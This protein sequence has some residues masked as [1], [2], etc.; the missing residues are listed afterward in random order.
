MNVTEPKVRTAADVDAALA[1]VI[2]SV[3]RA[4][5]PHRYEQH[6][7]VAALEHLWAEQHY[8][9]D[10]LRRLHERVMVGGR[11]LALELDRYFELDD[12]GAKND[13][14]IEVGT[15]LGEQAIREA[16]DAVGLEPRD[17]DAIF[18]TTVTGLAAPTIDARLVNRLEMRRDVVRTP[19][20]GLGCVAGA[21]G[22][23]R[24][25]DYLRAYPDKVAVLLSVELC[26]LTLQPEDLSVTNVIASGLFG[27][28]AAAVVG[29]GAHR[30]AELGVSGPRAMRHGS[31]F[32]RDTEW[33]MGWDI[34][35]TGFKVV[36]SAKL[37]QLIRDRLADD[38]DEFLASAG[39]RR[40]ELTGWVAHPGGP[41]V[42]EAMQ[43][44]LGVGREAFARTWDSLYAIGNL[45]SASVL[46]VLGDT[47][48]DG[49]FEPGDDALMMAMGPGFCAEMVL[50]RW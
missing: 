11:N 45:S 32:Y 40:S 24:M 14:F 27:D 26:S 6:E 37:P 41:A 23:G 10:R 21:A 19:M 5:P 12:F 25:A 9:K 34:G 49:A 7:L 4:L 15:N 39:L 29:V 28:G 33:V 8:N 2:A 46:F 1:P 31:A 35:S 36:L 48:A 38:V 13:A 16:L 22:V 43:D 50:L 18:F 44:A 3:S 20:F 30:A 17:V 47:I 42:L